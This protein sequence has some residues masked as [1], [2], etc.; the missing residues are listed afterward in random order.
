MMLKPFVRSLILLGLCSPIL[1]ADLVSYWP[2]DEFED[3]TSTPDVVNG[4]D[5]E[6]FFLDDTSF[7]DSANHVEG[8]N[9]MAFE[10]IN[11]D[12]SILAR[13]HDPDDLLPINQHPEYTISFWTKTLG[14]GQNDLRLISEG[15]SEDNNPLFNIGT[16]NNGNDNTLDIFIRNGGST[17]HQRTN[18]MPFDDEW[19]HIAWT[20]S[21]GAHSI[22]IDGVFDRTVEWPSFGDSDPQPL[23]NTSVGGI[24]RAAPS[25]WVTGIIDDVAMWNEVLPGPSISALA[26]GSKD[27]LSALDVLLGDFNNDGEISDLDYDILVSN[28]RDEGTFADG[29]I[30]GDG[31]INLVDFG[32]FLDAA[33]AAGVSVPQAVPEPTGLGWLLSAIVFGLLARKRRS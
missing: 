2:F 18:G 10:F 7:F 12:T 30:N 27:P 24:L 13:E 23:N 31:F 17:G 1:Q 25:H 3:E 9:G 22:F 15:S 21:E 32:A 6:V 33:D 11:E 5:L 20:F 29:D 16:A 4:Y 8:K 14:E 28:F 26:D 19:R